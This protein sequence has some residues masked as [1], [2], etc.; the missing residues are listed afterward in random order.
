VSVQESKRPKLKHKTQPTTFHFKFSVKVYT[1]RQLA[2]D[3]QYMTTH[4]M[5]PKSRFIA[6]MLLLIT[7]S[8]LMVVYKSAVI[9]MLEPLTT[10]VRHHRFSGILAY[11][12]LFGML[13]VALVPATIP[14]LLGG[15]LFKEW[16][17]TF[18]S[19]R[20]NCRTFGVSS[21]SYRCRRN[22]SSVQPQ[23]IWLNVQL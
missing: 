3:I 5:A 6:F 2:T 23:I 13:T 22:V 16:I 1:V 19:Y 10:W 11:I 9:I 4:T 14:T 21:R 15:M 7:C 12:G 8:A 20:N 18:N 17:G